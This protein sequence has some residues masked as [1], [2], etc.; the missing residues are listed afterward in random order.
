MK[1]IVDILCIVIGVPALLF[2]VYRFY[3]FATYKLP[4]GEYDAVGNHSMHL[5]YW[6]IAATVVALACIL[7]YFL[8]HVNKEEEIHITQ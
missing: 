1:N 3:E 4:T 5:L 6:A 7:I 8:R 2:A